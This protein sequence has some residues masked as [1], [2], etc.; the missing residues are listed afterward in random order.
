MAEQKVNHC[1]QNLPASTVNM[2]RALAENGAKYKCAK[3]CRRLA[4]A[5]YKCAKV[6]EVKAAKFEPSPAKVTI[7]Q[8]NTDAFQEHYCSG[9]GN[10]SQPMHTCLSAVAFKVIESG[11]LNLNASRMTQSGI[12]KYADL[13]SKLFLKQWG[14]FSS[15]TDVYAVL[16]QAL[17]WTE[18]DILRLVVPEN[19]GER[20]YRR[21]YSLADVQDLHSRI[22]LV[23]GKNSQ[24]T[25]EKEVD[26]D[27]FT[28]IFDSYVKT[29][30]EEYNHLNH[31]TIGQLIILQ[32]EQVKDEG[33]ISNDVFPLLSA[34]KQHCSPDDLKFAMTKA[35]TEVE[36]KSQKHASDPTST[37]R[38]WCMVERA[39]ERSA[40]VKE[41]TVQEKPNTWGSLSNYLTVSIGSPTNIGSA[42]MI[43]DLQ[44]CW[45]SFLGSVSAPN[46][47]YM[48]LE[49]LGII[50]R[51]L[52]QEDC[53]KRVLP[54]HFIEG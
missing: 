27:M 29:K 20:Q 9:K 4:W 52:A 23:S 18:H 10:Y 42:P 6:Q 21:T 12:L 22:M 47:D 43:S 44:Q 14:S 28:L 1:G 37:T 24:D 13:L 50:L 5:K 36:A 39:K 46:S 31:F 34:I 19:D 54:G 45:K 40:P 35:K 17:T 41:E 51:H 26:V 49:H 48:S 7:S 11:N 53:Y 16:E 8:I 15:T 32:R 2:R 38:Q 3:F 30:R 25:K 33:H